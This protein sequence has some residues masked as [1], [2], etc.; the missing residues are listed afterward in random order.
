MGYSYGYLLITPLKTTHEPPSRAIPRTSA[1]LSPKATQA[2][3]S[4]TSRPEASNPELGS[5]VPYLNNTC[6]VDSFLTGRKHYE[7]K[8]YTFPLDTSKSSNLQAPNPNQS[9]LVQ[10]CFFLQ[11]A[12]PFRL[13]RSSYMKP[14]VCIPVIENSSIVV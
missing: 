9:L 6:F 13:F 12:G 4:A 8:V 5:G 7:T 2:Q 14:A 11:V 3:H 1:G 10:G